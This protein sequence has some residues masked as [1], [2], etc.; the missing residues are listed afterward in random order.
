M[1]DL[2]KLNSITVFLISFYYISAKNKHGNWFTTLIPGI[3]KVFDIP[4]IIYVIKKGISHMYSL[5]AR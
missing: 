3:T 1:A 4:I 5:K 2:R